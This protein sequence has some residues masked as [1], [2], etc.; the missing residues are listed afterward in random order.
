MDMRFL[1]LSSTRDFRASLPGLLN[2]AAGLAA[3]G[4]DTEAFRVRRDSIA[5]TLGRLSYVA[6]YLVGETDGILPNFVICGQMTAMVESPRESNGAVVASGCS[7]S[8][9]SVGDKLHNK[10][11][12][13]S[14][15]PR[16][17]SSVIIS[18][19]LLALP[20]SLSVSLCRSVY[21][22]K[23]I[24]RPQNTSTFL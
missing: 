21:A 17:P 9:A 3:L 12:L 15:S 19:F 10:L 6:S 16:S 2:L 14:S 13:F 18:L 24:R 20:V 8:V 5:A 23:S 7:H 22:C 11:C 1:I 4:R